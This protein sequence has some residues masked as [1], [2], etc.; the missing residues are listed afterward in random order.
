M[1]RHLL[2]DDDLTSAEQREVLTRAAALKADR[3]ADRSL[4]GPRSVAVIFD[5]PTLRTQLSFTVGISELGGYPVMVDGGLA[6]IGTR[7]SIADVTRV[8]TRQ[9]AAIVWRTYGQDRI[10]EM[11]GA[12]TVPVVN[13]LTDDFHPC[14]ILADLLTIAEHTGGLAGGVD[15][16]GPALAGR[17][18]AYL[19]DGG[20]N[21]A[22]SYL[23]G[24]ALAG[25]D[26][27]IGAPAGYRPR[28]D[29]LARAEAIAATTGGSITVTDDPGAA[30]SGADAVATDTWVSMGQEDEASE[31][32][33][34]FRPFQLDGDVLALAAPAAVVLHCLPAYRGKEITAEVLDGPRSV[35]WDEAENRL[36]AQKAVLSFLLDH[37]GG[38]GARL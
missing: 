33:A 28:A 38:P 12:A 30:V 2:A 27:R 15:G 37:T 32:L 22:H 18:L 10:E 25:L 16:A 1:T 24:G 20:N 7:E 11:A 21:M 9:V 5:K 14:Q 35:V 26:V 6:Q 8:L 34:P 3:F 29:L 4:A 19:G 23:L 31:R 13:A 17:T 36:H